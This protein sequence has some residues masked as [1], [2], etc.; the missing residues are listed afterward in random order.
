[1]R[2]KASAAETGGNFS[3]SNW[4]IDY[5]G[6]AF[7]RSV[8]YCEAHAINPCTSLDLRNIGLGTIGANSSV[9]QLKDTGTQSA[10]LF[11]CWLNVDNIQ[12]YTTEYLAAV[13]V[14]GPLWRGKFNGVGLTGPRLYHRQIVGDDDRR[15][16]GGGELHRA[17]A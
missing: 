14:D 17:P 10:Q 13:D 3:L 12:A 15:R 4:K 8:F 16:D 9:I 7:S 11:P 5:E 1:M 6:G 2:F